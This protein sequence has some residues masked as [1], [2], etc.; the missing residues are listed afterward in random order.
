MPGPTALVMSSESSQT[1]P[2]HTVDA[3]KNAQRRAPLARGTCIGRYLLLEPVGTGGMGVVYKAIDPQ[4]NRPI[5][6]KL[7]RAD[8]ESTDAQ[9]DRLLREAQALARL[10]HPNVVAVF[11]VGTF[12]GDV[13]IAMELVEGRTLRAWL[14]DAKPNRREIVSAFC[15]AGEG[16]AAAHRAG[17]VHRDF[18]P[19]NAIIGDDG[20]VRVLDFGLARTAH[21]DGE[22]TPSPADSGRFA[23]PEEDQATVGDRRSSRE[24]RPSPKPVRAAVPAPPPVAPADAV[25]LETSTA[26]P[27]LLSSPLTHAGAITG[28]PRFMAPEQ[29]LG[30]PVDERADQFSFCISLYWALYGV[31]PFTDARPEDTLERVLT[32]R[33]CDPPPGATVPRWLRQVLVKGLSAR[34]ENRY[35]SMTA[36]LEALRAD[37]SRT[38]LR[39][40]RAAAAVALVGGAAFAWY[41]A[42]R[43]EMRACAGAGAKLAGIWDEP[44]RASLRTTFRATHL[45]Y[46]ETVLATVERGLDGYAHAWET[47]H[48]DACEATLVRHEQSQELL[49][50][51][52]SCLSDRLLKLRTLTDLYTRADAN[53][54]E[55]AAQSLESLPAIDHCADAAALKAPVPPPT[56]RKALAQVQDVREKLAQANALGLAGHY[57]QSIALARTTAA[58]AEQIHYRPIEAE[59]H[60]TLGDQL[61]AH[62][63]FAA[64]ST[65]YHRALS[66][67]LAGR[68][69][70]IAATAA[71]NLINATGAHQAHYEEADRWVELAEATLERLSQKEELEALFYFYRSDLRSFEDKLDP[72][73]ADAKQALALYEHRF[74]PNDRRVAH[75]LGVL[76]Q[77]QYARAEF[78][79]ALQSFERKRAIEEKLLGPEHP[80]LAQTWIGLGNVVGDIGRHAEA[81]ADYRRALEIVMR[82][83]PNHPR[84]AVI[85]NNLGQDLESQGKQNEAYEQYQQAFA[86]GMR[87]QGPSQITILAQLN[88]ASIEIE[89]TRYQE[90]KRR[91]QDALADEEKVFGLEHHLRAKVLWYIGD[92]NAEEKQYDQALAYYGRA[93][94]IAEKTLNALDPNLAALFYNMAEVHLLRHEPR[95]AIPLFERSLKIRE[96]QPGNGSSLTKVRFALAQALWDGGGDRVRAV[97]LAAQARDTWAAAGEPARAK[98]AEVTKWLRERKLR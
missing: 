23:R 50:L 34:P 45:P 90:A 86:F 54:V 59:G 69:D 35:P 94:P 97:A 88:M 51:R 25:L 30:D 33:V 67:A 20:R 87:T 31:F 13:F 12:G 93:L 19:D 58:A 73:L 68:N 3:K 82:V 1:D 17:L 8:E 9:R 39:W 77:V 92:V 79:P 72:A 11:D 42:H 36:L 75:A 62:G 16:L 52:M 89:Q 27:N 43:M 5:A 76:G 28:T 29:H 78:A 37:P 71:I 21:N 14:A 38:R 55:Q 32:G 40:L 48:I 24:E 57:D 83:N 4:L 81:I 61:A 64:A 15:E 74:G 91:L 63:D 80:E 46:V 96:A 6:L 18:K 44:R 49:D 2:D 56:D 98:L 53:L 47:M 70:V 7:L 95:Q 41:E 26:T 60:L 85:Y 10:Q 84:I 66:S 22:A 65:A